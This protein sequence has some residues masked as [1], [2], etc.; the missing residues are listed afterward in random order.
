VDIN[1]EFTGLRPGEKMYEELFYQNEFLIKTEHQ[2]LFKANHSE[3]DWDE[4][5]TMLNNLQQFYLQSDDEQIKTF[6]QQAV[7]AE[8]Q[9]V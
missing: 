3:I 2:K 5:L 1:I 7:F 9:M 6:L 8:S 4:Y